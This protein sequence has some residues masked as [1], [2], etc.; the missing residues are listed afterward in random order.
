MNFHWLKASS[1]YPDYCYINLCSLNSKVGI[2]DPP[3][4]YHIKIESSYCSMNRIELVYYTTS[5]NHFKRL[6]QHFFPAQAIHHWPIKSSQ[7]LTGAIFENCK[8][9]RF[10]YLWSPLS[11]FWCHIWPKICSRLQWSKVI[12]DGRLKAQTTKGW[13]SMA[14]K[15]WA[16]HSNRAA[17]PHGW[18]LELNR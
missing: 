10:S 6:F 14:L 4:P 11:Y 18:K 8:K 17:Q 3:N 2:D 15:R 13:L 12:G 5:I 1:I 7:S 9:K 16:E